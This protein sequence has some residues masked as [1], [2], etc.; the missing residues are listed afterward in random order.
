LHLNRS[1]QRKQGNRLQAGMGC[2]FISSVA[3]C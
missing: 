3:F 1:K 2:V